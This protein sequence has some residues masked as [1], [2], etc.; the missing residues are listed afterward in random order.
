[1]TL[2]GIAQLKHDGELLEPL[3]RASTGDGRRVADD[4]RLHAADRAGRR[5]RALQRA[6]PAA[7]RGRR[8]GATTIL[9]DW[10]FSSDE[11]PHGDKLGRVASHR[12]TY[13]VYIDRPQKVAEL[14]PLI[15][16]LT[17]EHGIV[18][19]LLVP[20]YRERAGETVNGTLEF[21]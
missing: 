21:A 11:Q 14:W 6:D 3:P 2:E 10:G 19:S 18:T 7:A 15:D 9:G 1:M 4:P 20:G 13:T 16:E 8:R 17:A 5:P 12:P